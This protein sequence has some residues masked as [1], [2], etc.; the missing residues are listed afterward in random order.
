MS[1]ADTVKATAL[2]VSADRTATTARLSV[3]AP[4]NWNP[5]DVWLTRVKQPREVARPP[6][7]DAALDAA[8]RD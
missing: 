1:W 4:W 8:L 5:H 6:C 7:Q 2:A 3:D